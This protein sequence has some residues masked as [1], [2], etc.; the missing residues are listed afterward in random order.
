MYPLYMQER[1]SEFQPF[2][3]TASF[4]GTTPH[5]DRPQA[6][7][8]KRSFEQI[9]LSGRGHN[10][11]LDGSVVRKGS[12]DSQ[13]LYQKALSLSVMPASPS[14]TSVVRTSS[15]DSAT[16][17]MRMSPKPN[18][19]DLPMPYQER[20]LSTC[21]SDS[22]VAS[23]DQT[24]LDGNA[25]TDHLKDPN[26]LERTLQYACEK[27]TVKEKHVNLE[28]LVRHFSMPLEKAA[29]QLGVCPTTLKKLCRQ[30]GIRRWPCR[31]LRREAKNRFQPSDQVQEIPDLES[32]IDVDSP[33]ARHLAQMNGPSSLTVSDLLKLQQPLNLTIPTT[34]SSGS[35]VSSPRSPFNHLTLSEAELTQSTLDFRHD[36]DLFSPKAFDISDFIDMP[37]TEQDVPNRLTPSGPSRGCSPLP[38]VVVSGTDGEQESTLYSSTAPASTGAP[39]QKPVSVES[40]SKYSVKA[41]YGDRMIRFIMNEG[42]TLEDLKLEL[43]NGL[44]PMLPQS[45]YGELAIKYKGM[46]GN[47]LWL[48]KESDY[49][50]CRQAAQNLTARKIYISVRW[51]PTPSPMMIQRFH[52]RTSPTPPMP[53]W[54]RS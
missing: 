17:A 15:L 29:K 26:L 48:I 40:R 34:P 4:N 32:F 50:L 6:I 23:T 47:W 33:I 45:E 1:S 38:L 24:L 31:K 11:T 5:E 43:L 20:R 35:S 9:P 21:S 2:Y 36:E 16:L 14:P 42:Q 44:G 13:L 7:T 25:Q 28:D 54:S 37:Q 19:M 39:P 52:Q 12:L 22:S 8:R 18:A 46:A 53:S 30:N 10:L 27:P 3:G 41:L 51:V 49:Y